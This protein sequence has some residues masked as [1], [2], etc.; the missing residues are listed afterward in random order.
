ML[1]SKWELKI[2]HKGQYSL[3]HSD[4]DGDREEREIVPTVGQGAGWIYYPTGEKE[5]YK[6]VL[7]QKFFDDIIKSALKDKKKFLKFRDSI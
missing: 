4:I 7:Y 6:Q 5:K 1:Y 3:E 2:N